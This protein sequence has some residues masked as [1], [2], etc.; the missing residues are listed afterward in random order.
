VCLTLM[1]YPCILK[2]VGSKLCQDN[3]YPERRFSL[4]S[5][6]PTGQFLHQGMMTS[7]QIL[8][9]SPVINHPIIWCYIV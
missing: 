2:V 6:C 7:F 8:K 5:I 1:L 4:L 9:N 3:G